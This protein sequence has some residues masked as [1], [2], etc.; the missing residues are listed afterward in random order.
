MVRVYSLDIGD[1]TFE[2]FVQDFKNTVHPGVINKATRYKNDR[3]KLRSLSAAVLLRH[4]L[5]HD[6]D[7]LHPAPFPCTRKGK[8]Y[9]SVDGHEFNTTHG[10]D[11]VVVATADSPV[12]VDVEH[13]RK[14]RMK[15]AERFFSPRELE[16]I[17]HAKD[18]DACFTT[19]WC[20]KESFLKYT[21]DGL[22]SP[23]NSFTVTNNDSEY[24]IM[25]N[26]TENNQIKIRYHRDEQD[27]FYAVCHA[28]SEKFSNIYIT[29]YSEL[30]ESLK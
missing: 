23:L 9:Y 20:I 15:V 4:A 7:L 10:K 5:K 2:K 26:N 27:Y 16:K 21:G 17:K 28:A 19:F 24:K 29:S 18:K 3:D 30:L 25:Q 12:G 11:R 14:N 22:T 8:P 1:L 6:F 13:K